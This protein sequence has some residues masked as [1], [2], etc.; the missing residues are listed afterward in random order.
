MKV[1]FTLALL[2]VP[3]AVSFAQVVV[4][5][6]QPVLP[7]YRPLGEY[8]FIDC[9][10]VETINGIT[11]EKWL[12]VNILTNALKKPAAIKGSFS[13]YNQ[14]VGIHGSAELLGQVFG[15]FTDDTSGYSSIVLKNGKFNINAEGDLQFEKLL[16]VGFD[17]TK[18]RAGFYATVGNTQ[19]RFTDVSGC[20]ISNLGL[21]SSITLL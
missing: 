19:S 18:T 20:K 5:P 7:V 9:H 1:I 15:R 2:A 13:F 6:L 11:N 3:S 10:A 4:S 8:S 16:S 12:K 21:F 14:T 17:S